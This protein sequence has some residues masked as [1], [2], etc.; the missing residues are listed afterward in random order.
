[1]IKLRPPVPTKSLAAAFRKGLTMYDSTL[2]AFPSRVFLPEGLADTLPE[3]VGRRHVDGAAFAIGNLV[4]R[5]LAFRHSATDSS[6][7]PDAPDGDGWLRVS[8]RFLKRIVGN[9]YNAFVVRPLI[10]ADVIER[11]RGYTVAGPGIEGKCKPYR[12]TGR[13]RQSPIRPHVIRDPVLQGRIDTKRAEDELSKCPV[14]RHLDQNLLRLTLAEGAPDASR[15]APVRYCSWHSTRCK[16]G[17]IHSPFCTIPGYRPGRE[18]EKVLR[19]H[20][21]LAGESLWSIDIVNSQPLLAACSFAGGRMDA[22]IQDYSF[23][24]QHARNGFGQWSSLYKPLGSPPRDG[25]RDAC[26]SGAIYDEV[27]N[28]V[29]IGRNVV[30]Q[31][32]FSVL[33]GPKHRS[34]VK[35]HPD[36]VVKLVGA[37]FE[38]LFPATWQRLK[39]MDGTAL[40]LSMQT[41]ESWLVLERACGR[42]MREMPDAP[43][44]SVHDS[45]VTTKAYVARFEEILSDAFDEAFGVRPKLKCGRFN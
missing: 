9:D 30:K 13:W 4:S 26:V 5:S 8:S 17:R 14:H 40:A 35:H 42:I 11:G 1:M 22:E 37:A 32:F 6:D 3:L 38:K 45:L 39:S 21:L 33:F 34:N 15:L 7:D 29:G 12:I 19:P 23:D 28:E 24:R 43:L 18:V 16:Q 20:L 44:L 10:H 31:A 41:V 2:T 27:A 36:P 25:F